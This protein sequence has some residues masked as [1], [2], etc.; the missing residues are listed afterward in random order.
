MLLFFQSDYD[1]NYLSPSTS[2]T[3]FDIT[4]TFNLHSYEDRE[5]TPGALH[6]LVDKVR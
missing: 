5:V 2:L 3:L 6:D 4:Y 1:I